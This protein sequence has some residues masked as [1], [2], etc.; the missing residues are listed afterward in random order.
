MTNTERLGLAIGIFG[1]GLAWYY[2]RQQ[3]AE[4][5]RVLALQPALPTATLGVDT[6]LLPNAPVDP[7]TQQ[8]IG[9]PPPQ[10]IDPTTIGTL[11]DPLTG[12]PILPPATIGATLVPGGY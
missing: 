1:I 12:A 9:L 8:P 4:F 11:Y 7:I 2:N 5:A 3:T 6:T 10:P